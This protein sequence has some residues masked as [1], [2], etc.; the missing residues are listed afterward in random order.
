MGVKSRSGR[1]A[2]GEDERGQTGQSANEAAGT[3][4]YEVDVLQSLR[5]II[6]AVELYS[7]RL[8]AEHDLTAPQLVCLLTVAEGGDTTASRLSARMHVSP[9]T[10]VGILDRLEARDLIARE[11][12]ATDRRVVRVSVTSK[13][14]RLAR[15][16][17]SPLQDNLA[18]ALAQLP[19]GEQATI[20]DSLRRIVDLM[21]ARELDASPILKTGGIDD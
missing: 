19:D 20:A 6:R 5:R 7:R 17:P 15:G 8:K 11:R 13:G 18:Q 16:A 1:S 12:D 3:R 10:V 9:S 21:E 2:P 14:R 4:S